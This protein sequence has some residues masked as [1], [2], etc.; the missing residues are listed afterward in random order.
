MS[1][2]YTNTSGIDCSVQPDLGSLK[3]KSVIVTGGSSG[4]GEAYVDAF[5]KAGAFVTNA[6]LKPNKDQEA[7]SN[8]Q[9]CPCDVTSWDQQLAAFKAAVSKS[10]H[11]TVDIV[12]ANA[13]I[14]GSDPIFQLE[15]T[16]EPT[17]PNLKIIQVDFIGVVYTAKLAMHYFNKQDPSRDRCLILKSSLAGFLDLPGATSYQ[18]SKFAVRGLMCNLR[19]AGRCRVNLVAPWYVNTPIMSE[20]VVKRIDDLLK[21]HGADWATI[22]DCARTVL[23]IAADSSVQG[24]SLAVVPH[25][26]SEHGYMDINYDDYEGRDDIKWL[27]HLCLYFNHRSSVP[28]DK[29]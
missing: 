19:R 26:V 24:R 4:L 21:K 15:D 3:D 1:F 2:E 13:G 17:E 8:Y 28:A 5:V 12:V 27:Q 16:D 6:D 18:S 22:E 25:S 29:Q 23:R 7:K 20:T 10:P 14:S 11:N 9:F